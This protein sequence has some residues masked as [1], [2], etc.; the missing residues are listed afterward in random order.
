MSKFTLKDISDMKLHP[1]INFDKLFNKWTPNLNISDERIEEIKEV[2][3]NRF[4]QDKLSMVFQLYHEDLMDWDTFS[5]SSSKIISK[6]N[7]KISWL[8]GL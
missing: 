4:L 1:S 6:M 5:K 8:F 7:L 2:S 3:R